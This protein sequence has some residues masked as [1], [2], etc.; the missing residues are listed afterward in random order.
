ML[1]KLAGVAN[2]H[3]RRN[4]LSTQAAT[5]GGFTPFVNHGEVR[6][7]KL[8]NPTKEDDQT[9]KPKSPRGKKKKAATEALK[10]D[11]AE[12]QVA[13]TQKAAPKKRAKSPA[14]EVENLEAKAFF[15]K[16]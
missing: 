1:S 16:E 11:T 5:A 12:L 13:S 7:F 4:L 3:M 8:Q 15:Q 14:P 2:A 6:F 9:V 10:N